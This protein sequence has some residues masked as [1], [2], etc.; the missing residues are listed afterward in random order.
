MKKTLAIILSILMMFAVLPVSGS[1][2]E[3]SY[4]RSDVASGIVA[5]LT[6]EQMASVILDWVDRQIAKVT[7]DFESFEVNVMGTTVA[8][9]IP[10]IKTLDD[11]ITYKDYLAKLEGDF[12]SLDTTNLI[13]REAAGSSLDFIYGVLQFMADNSEIFGKV[14]QWE[15][16]KVFDYGKVGE[17][18]EALDPAVE[19]NK[20]I[21]DFYNN[22]LIGNDIQDKFIDWVAAQM[23]YEYAVDENGERNEN[24]DDIINNGILEWF[25]GVCEQMGILS[26]D[27]IAALKAY[28]LRTTDIYT[29]VKNLVGLVESDNE[30]KINTYYTYLLDTVVRS[31][32][33]TMLGQSA[34]VGAEAELPASFNAVYTDLA[35]LETVSGGNVYY[36]DGENYYAVTVADGIATAKT[37]AWEN[38]LDVEFNP[39][40]VGVYTG[41]TDSADKE[42]ATYACDLVQEYRPAM[43]YTMTIYSAYADQINGQLG[44]MPEGLTLA[45]TNEAIPAEI[46]ALMVEDNAKSMQ[47][48]FAF[49]VD[50]GETNL[51]SQVITFQQIA[52]LA[53]Q[54]ALEAAQTMGSAMIGT[55]VSGI[56][57]KELQINDI[58]IDL[59][60]N[61]YATEDEF[62]CQVSSS[63]TADVKLVGSMEVMG[64]TMDIPLDL[65]GFDVS[66]YINNP[67]A[68]IVLDNLSGSLDIDAA[69]MLPDFIDT[70][71]V[72]DYEPIAVSANYDTYNGVVGQAN[73]ILYGIVDMLVSDNGMQTLGLV[74]GDNT[75]LTDNLQKVCDTVNDMM[76]QAEELLNDAGLQELLKTAGVDVAEILNGLNLDLLYMIDFSSVEALYV[77]A[78]SLGLDIIDDGSN[79]TITAVHAALEG[80]ATLDAMAV[81]AADYLLAECI[82]AV[83][84]L[85]E[86]LKAQYTDVEIGFELSVPAKTDVASVADGAGKDIIMTKA[87][88]VLYEAAVEGVALANAIANDVLADVATEIGMDM[89]TV[90][91]EL[92]VAK[93]A[94]WAETLAALVNRVYKLTDGIIIACDNEYTDTFDKISA[95]ANAILPLGSLASNCASENFAFDINTVMG[96]LFNDGLEG[97]LEGFLRLFETA[98]KTADVAAGVPVTKALI[99]ASQHIVDSIFPGT[100]V[101]ENYEASVTVQEEFTSGENDVVIASNNMDSINNRKADLVPAALNLVREAGILPYFAKCELDHTATDL[102][103]VLIPGTAA[104]CTEDGVEDA[105]ACADCGYIVRGGGVITASGHN[106]TSKVT[107]AATCTAEGVETFTC[108]TCGDT[109]TKSIAKLSHSYGAWTAKTDA[110]C[111]ADGVSERKCAC[112]KTETKAIPA[113]GHADADSNYVCDN[114][115]TELEKPELNFFEKIIAFFQSIIDFFKNLFS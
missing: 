44:E 37:L 17:Y 24:F 114:C 84:T 78:I 82:P 56:T 96:Y 57:V 51:L 19:E 71:F 20:Q 65:P 90:A 4:N 98:E 108:A 60:Y 46:T 100:V 42:I 67:V 101:A 91:F 85:V 105:Y 34:V 107:S 10:E 43:D 49:T 2:A 113:T 69:A 8:V 77:S 79:E 5:D 73:H 92:K 35:L 80:C 89:P 59:A 72:I 26:A 83:N 16:G 76:A 15:A 106:H 62:I 58:S 64:T 70:D 27:G 12:A 86:D 102:A 88:D 109:Y 93:G 52:D 97:D 23:K 54:K 36:K 81:A 28:D 31:L 9:D 33:K 22:Y 6:A 7:E 104:T 41:A 55:Q 29:L 14:F 21:I 50:M 53:E 115:G 111:T 38:T 87:V 110:T 94:D 45:I 95:V 103:T 25:A 48:L 66:S 3:T 40:V 39:P 61:G 99:N 63:A 18:I 74:D 112:G 68:T 75:N 1:A 30:V 47:D 32:V 11:V 13:T